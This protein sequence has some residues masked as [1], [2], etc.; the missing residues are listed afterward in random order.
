MNI[1][2]R[3][4]FFAAAACC[5]IST[6]SL[7][8]KTMAFFI[9]IVTIVLFLIVFLKKNQKFLIVL[10]SIALFTVS[11]IIEF[12]KVDYI[13]AHDGENL[14][15]TFVV[16]ENTTDYDEYNTVVLRE[17]DSDS[18]PNE[19]KVFMFD[20]KKTKLKIGDIINVSL[21][22]N[23]MPENNEYRLSNYGEG[24]YATANAKEIKKL[25]KTDWFYKSLGSIRRYVSETVFS[26]FDGDEA[27]LLV[28]ITTGDKSLLSDKFLSN[29]KTTGISHVIV[30]SGMHLSIIMAA[31][32]FCID[33]FF[34]NKYIRCAL[35]VTAVL[36]IYS[37]CG[38][39]TSI[40]RAGAMFIAASFAPVFGRDND[41]L[42]SLLTAITAVLIA[43][44]FTIFNIS[45]L[46]SVLSTLAIIWI[47]PFYFKIV[48]E[49]FNIK[50][51]IL[52]G[53]IGSLLCSIFAVI[54]TMPVTIKIFGYVSIVG[55]ITNMIINLPIT[56]ALVLNILALIVAA[57][58]V[59]EYISYP[60]F[61]LAGLCSN[62]TVY[63]VNLI[64]SLPITVAVLPKRTFWWSVLIVLAIISYMYYYEYK[65][66]RSDFCACN[67]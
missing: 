15:G 51:I 17:K 52:K 5:V 40:T 58:P 9:A 18:I 59:I 6:I 14:Y 63:V 28:A 48:I 36:I 11:L 49:R 35:S 31:I 62:F 65:K 67:I 57:F 13:D 4:M 2:K 66:K 34:Y 25:E 50:S 53:I 42:S 23:A 43:M 16:V 56:I 21:T 26:S 30:V 24:I 7:F 37:I 38:F 32:Y 64:A 60:V 33:K 54:F 29:V 46:L 55:P 45:F 1:L 8:E 44:P 41:S 20:Y 47:V 12:A 19:T 27:G 39:T 61:W 10:I 22:L 3:P